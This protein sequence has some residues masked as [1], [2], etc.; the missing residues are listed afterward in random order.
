MAESRLNQVADAE[1]AD[2]R[3][4]DLYRIG[5]ISCIAFPASIVIAVVVYFIWPYAPGF[6]SVADI[7]AVLQNDR[8]AGLMSIELSVIVLLPI[9]IPQLLAV[10][11]ALKR[12]N[13]SY[14]LIALVLGLMG[15]GIFF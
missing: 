2:M 13:E 9:M 11:V 8:L 15:V 10:Y 14:A 12:V 7:F 5:C 4:K 3:W 6:T 1:V